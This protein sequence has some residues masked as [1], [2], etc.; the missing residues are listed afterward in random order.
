M[1][2]SPR[3]C[4][5][6]SSFEPINGL[7]WNFIW[8]LHHWSYHDTNMADVRNYEQ[9]NAGC[10]NSSRKMLCHFNNMMIAQNLYVGE[11]E[12]ILCSQ[13][14]LSDGQQVQNP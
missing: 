4:V 1:C 11:V 3:V 10:W 7:P 9:F 12:V 6:V 8:T 2:F 5:C 13:F 14:I